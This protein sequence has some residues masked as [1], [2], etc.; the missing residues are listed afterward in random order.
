ML[1]QFSVKNFMSLKNE[2]IVSMLAGKETLLPENKFKVRNEELLKTIAIYGANASGKSCIYKAFTSAI[3]MVRLSER[4]QIGEKFMEIVPFKF[5]NETIE[6]PSEFEFIFIQDEIK[7]KYGFSAN[8]ER[9]INEYLY[10]YI[11]SKPSLIFERKNTNEYKFPKKHEKILNELKE[12]N[13]E[14]KLF[15]STATSWNYEETKKAFM[16][17]SRKIDTY[18]NFNNMAGDLIQKLQ[19]DNTG[20]LKKFTLKMLKAADINI[21]D[22]LIRATPIDI[23]KILP[24]LPY[25]LAMQIKNDGKNVIGFNNNIVT[26]HTINSDKNYFLEMLEESDGTQTIFYLS[27]ILKETLEKGKILIIDEIDSGLHPLLVKY[28]VSL[29]NNPDINIGNAQLIF[30]TH[31]TNLLSLDFL[32]RDQIY[33]TEKEHDTG[34]TEL[35]SLDEFSV[36]KKENIQKGYL[37]GRYGAIP[38]LEEEDSLWE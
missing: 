26:G 28:I 19:E 37:Q 34:V 27:P 31:D 9:I 33:L 2:V 10:K 5:D 15:L 30:I 29:F 24:Q 12:K 14:N 22:Y 6:N 8:G 35:Y 25:Q 16:W 7:Y 13:I 32:R 21:S 11:S 17:F 36:R 23:E 20:E 18:K 1:V 4:R 3:M 38:F